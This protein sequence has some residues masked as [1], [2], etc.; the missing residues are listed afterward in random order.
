M[1]PRRPGSKTWERIKSGENRP[2]NDIEKS[3]Q[4]IEINN[5]T[6]I[7]KRNKLA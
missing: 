6:K 5:L 3:Y 1:W 7:I 4:Q 2:R